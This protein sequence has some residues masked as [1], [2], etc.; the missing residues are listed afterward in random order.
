M[1]IIIITFGLF[2]VSLFLKGLSHDILLDTGIFLVSVKLIVMSFRN[3][4]YVQDLNQQ[5]DE[6]K[7]LIKKPEPR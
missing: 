1:A 7:S 3:N 6:I 2:V 5:L 4:Q